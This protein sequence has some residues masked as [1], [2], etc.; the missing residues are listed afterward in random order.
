MYFNSDDQFILDPEGE[1][2]MHGEY[3]IDEEGSFTVNIGRTTF[4]GRVL[5]EDSLRVDYRGDIDTLVASD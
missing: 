3:I 1:E 4:T 2:R 5:S